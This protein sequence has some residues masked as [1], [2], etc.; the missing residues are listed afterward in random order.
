MDSPRR[1]FRTASLAIPI[2]LLIPQ[3]S[4]AQPTINERDAVLQSVLSP[5]MMA[6]H[7]YL[8]SGVSDKLFISTL[9]ASG[10]DV[11]FDQL[12][13]EPDATDITTYTVKR[14]DT[15]DSIAALFKVSRNTIRWQ[16]DIKRGQSIKPGQQLII[17]P[18]TGVMHKVVKGDT[19]S[20]IAK[21][22]ASA[23]EDIKNFNDIQ[24]DAEIIIGQNII[25]PNGEKQEIVKVKPVS[26]IKKVTQILSKPFIRG[27]WN[28]REMVVNGFMHPTQFNG[29]K[30]Q[31]FHDQY[32]AIDIGTPTG[33]PIFAS[34]SGM[35]KI[36]NKSGFGGG[37]GLYVYIEHSDGSGTM[38]AHM[39]KVKASAG[40]RVSQ[41]DVIGLVGSTGRS[42]GPHLHFEIRAPRGKPTRTWFPVPW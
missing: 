30:T 40:Q 23:P 27:K 36:A 10:T 39:S 12:Y 35:I 25:I 13:S 18:V 15:L 22:Y 5:A 8:G 16:N 9:T 3:T 21:L 20:K 29:I 6:K 19:I 24:S 7:L 17:L 38:Y 31:G 33:T 14:E 32:G 34:K 11:N 2:F 1:F 42:T 28:N 41:G 37:Y 26:I 4:L